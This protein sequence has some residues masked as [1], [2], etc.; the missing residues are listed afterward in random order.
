MEITFKNLQKK[1][2]P[3]PP[4]ILKMTKRALRHEGV[5]WAELSVVFVSSQKI[6]A[7][8]RNYLGRNHVTDV[9]AFN[10][11]EPLKQTKKER[12]TTVTGDIIISTD[13]AIKNARV[14]GNSVAH[15][16][17][18]YIVHGL[19]HLLGYDDHSARKTKIMRNKERE[20]MAYLGNNI[21]SIIR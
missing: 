14:Y 9:L 19:L 12:R 10:A 8:N 18:L 20:L 1:I 21:N 4:R 6:K 5:N 2:S 13:T 15:E 17:A 16:L 3:N 7:F 11:A